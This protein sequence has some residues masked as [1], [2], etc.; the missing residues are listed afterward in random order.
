[1]EAL[2][3]SEARY[4]ALFENAPVGICLS[5]LSGE[6]LACNDVLYHMTG[7][8][9]AELRQSNLREVY[10]D[11][12]GGATLWRWLQTDGDVR[13]FEMASRRKDGTL[14]YA[15]LTLTT[16]TIEGQETLVIMC[17][18]VTERVRAEEAL[19]RS[20]EEVAR[21]HRLLLAL[22][23]AAQTV[24]RAHTPD[25]V[26]QTIAHEV[27]KLGYHAAILALADD[28]TYL[29]ASHLTLDTALLRT[30]MEL[31]G[32]PTL[33]YRFALV[34]G[35]LFERLI[36]DGEV[37]F[38]TQPT[39]WIAE[40]LPA[41]TRPLAG[42]LTALLGVERAIFA[43]L[44]VGG[45]THGLLVVIGDDLSAAEAPAMVTFAHQAAIAIESAQLHEAERAARQ[46]LRDLAEYLQAARE[47]E[48]TRIARGIHDELGQALTALKMDLAWLAKRLPVELPHLGER[49]TTMS[50]LIDDTMQT[51]RHIA[52]ELR[53]GLLDNLGLTAATE[54]QTQEFAQRTGIDC[55]V[56]LSEEEVAVDPDVSTALFRILQ[57]ALTN[58]ARHAEATK[59]TVDL[60]EGPKELVMVIRD[61]GR[62]ITESEIANPRS[63]GLT[64]MRERARSW[65]GDV[66]FQGVPGRGTTVTVRIPRPSAESGRA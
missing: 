20:L 28:R 58:V 8:S 11:P 51:V 30:A 54:W 40:A 53:P 14:Y 50:D 34:P 56:H 27:V 12:E 1:V 33:G 32:L 17:T 62:G 31:T 23:E 48:R 57:E 2:R 43:P 10:Q 44:E 22:S 35:G 41:P 37:A 55:E 59:V 25:E 64:G 45:E 63:L 18:E 7:Y 46:R 36:A 47:E 3:E 65:G 15:K 5:T 19:R 26:Y 6:I 66:A 39:E 21:G 61:N 24:Q 4:R 52:T 29:T 49:A 9:E 42:R 16:V 60:E 13:D 38:V